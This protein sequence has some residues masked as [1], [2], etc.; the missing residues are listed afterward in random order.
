MD[1]GD[2]DAGCKWGVQ[3]N[4][5]LL[6]LYHFGWTFFIFFFIPLLPLFLTNKRV[7]E[8]LALDLPPAT[9][10]KGS[11]W[12]HALSVGEVL[13]AI[14]LARH[15]MGK[16]PSKDIVLTVTTP[17]GMKIA[18]NDLGGEATVLLTMPLDLWW[19]TRRI[20][21]FIKPSL[22]ILVETDI[23]PGLIAYLKRRGIK[24]L[25]INGRIS[26]RTFKSYRRFRF[27]TRPMLNA[28]ELCMMQSDLDRRRL[29]TIGVGQEKAVTVGNIKFDREWLPMSGEEHDH[30][31][32]ALNLQ[33]HDITWIA[34]S[35]HRGEEDIVLDVF[36]RLQPLFPPLRLIIAPRRLE[37]TGDVWRLSSRKGFRT[38][39]R[40]EVSGKKG[41]YDVLILDTIGE[42][43]RLYGVAKVSFVGGS[44]VPIGG[45]NLLEPAIFGLPVLFG[46]YTHNFVLMSRLLIE[47]GAG[48]K[49]SDGEELFETMK[50]LLSDPEKSDRMGRKAREFVETNRGALERVAAHIEAYLDAPIAP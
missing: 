42:L 2:Q 50:G 34:G 28:L 13:S 15:L 22:F 32:N 24:T 47:A 49:V 11:I 38:A 19:S 31:L 46:P 37:R 44:L 4:K 12:I 14:P 16:Y 27:F 5:V 25:W 45:H 21:H 7:L 48:K 35:T 23:W 10:K 41:R 29:L 33:P 36:R 18:R 30:W 39:L 1:C 26:P 3:L 20:V 6:F 40:T 8:K 43:E 17:Q 9:P